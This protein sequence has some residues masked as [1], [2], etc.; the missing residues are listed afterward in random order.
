MKKQQLPKINGAQVRAI[1][2]LFLFVGFLFGL[3]LFLYSQDNKQYIPAKII[4]HEPYAL[5]VQPESVLADLPVNLLDGTF[6]HEDEVTDPQPVAV[7]I[8]NYFTVAHQA[9]LSQASFIYETLAEGGATRYMVLFD[10]ERDIPKIGPI[11]SARPYFVQLA[12]EYDALY[13]HAGGSPEALAEIDQWGVDNLNEI[14]GYGTTY[15]YR[16]YSL[17]APHNLFTD[18]ERMRQAVENWEL[19]NP[20]YHV[21][22]FKTESSLDERGVDQQYISIDFTA[23]T[24]YDA[25]FAYQRD[26]N[27]YLRYRQGTFA[28]DINNNQII[29][30]K[31]VII[32]FVDPEVVLDDKLRIS[33]D[34]FGRGQ[35]LLFQDG[36][37]RDITW[38]KELR[39]ERTVFYESMNEVS[40]N[41]GLT[42]I[43]IVPGKREI[44]Y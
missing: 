27:E 35:G 20:E 21:W 43:V 18:N 26:T 22:Q 28:K 44:L 12:I 3:L 19:D 23:G 38:K 42:W 30:A 33:L 31:N 2:F 4:L 34:L 15:F 16:D 9:G 10:P 40:L 24:A 29:S 39:G 17:D 1:L 41:P 32:Q 7:M 13:V 37:V 5:Q 6:L 11:R 14:S 25:A 36:Q 8:D